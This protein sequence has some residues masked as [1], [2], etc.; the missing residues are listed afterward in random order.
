MLHLACK[1][2]RTLTLDASGVL[3]KNDIFCL[4]NTNYIKNHKYR[5]KQGLKMFKEGDAIRKRKK[6]VGLDKT[7]KIVCTMENLIF[8]PVLAKPT[9]CFAFPSGVKKV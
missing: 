4:L 7:E 5:M 6:G 3:G 2:I 8:L 1:T 9:F